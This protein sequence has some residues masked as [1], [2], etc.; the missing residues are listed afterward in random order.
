MLTTI[1][2]IVSLLVLILLIV[3][4]LILHRFFENLLERHANSRKRYFEPYVLNLL[5]DPTAT[6]PLECSQL[7]S[8]RKFVKELLLQQADQL[9]GVDKEN[10][11]TVFEKLG[12]VKSE[13]IALHS[14]RWW[15]RLEAAVNLGTMQ[16]R[17]A[18]PALIATVRDPVEDVRLAAVR[19]LGQLNEPKGLQVLLEAIEEEGERWTVSNVIEVLVGIGPSIAPRI[20]S[21]LKSTANIN[22]RLLYVQLSGLLRIPEA[23]EI[24]LLLLRDSHRET[25]ISAAQAL[26]QIG[27]ILAVKSLIISLGDESWEVRAQA[28]KALGV[29]G[30][31]QAV[32][33]LKQALFD[34]SW[35]VRH[36]AADS[37][38]QLGQEGME[39]LREVSCLSEGSPRATATQILAE[40]ALG[41]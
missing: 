7:S 17:D 19:T 27:D 28:A 5:N 24:L 23:V 9:K 31:K 6:G 11:A 35:W 36:N 2:A 4:Y 33:R 25:R 18:V 30:D 39:A 13:M 34:E 10:M 38:Y 41:I 40:R 14:R 37:L 21:R 22:S 1:Y 16:G 15:R 3:V 26:G 20:I 29:L 32:I 12:Y 8:D